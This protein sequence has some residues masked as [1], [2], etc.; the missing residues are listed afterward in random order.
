[1]AATTTAERRR[2]YFVYNGAAP[3]KDIESLKL[4]SWLTFL[5]MFFRKNGKIKCDSELNNE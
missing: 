5:G 2:K 3:A 1:M 4:K